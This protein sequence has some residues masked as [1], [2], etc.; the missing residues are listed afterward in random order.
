LSESLSRTPAEVC[1]RETLPTSWRFVSLSSALADWA[2]AGRT[3]AVA[4][5]AVTLTVRAHF[6]MFMP[7]LLDAIPRFQLF[8]ARRLTS[9]AGTAEPIALAASII[10]FRWRNCFLL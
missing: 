8:P 1:N 2:A 5:K 3:S 9:L 7:C 6:R 10:L 4:N